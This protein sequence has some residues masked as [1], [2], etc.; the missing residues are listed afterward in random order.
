MASLKKALFKSTVPKAEYTEIKQVGGPVKLAS[1][2]LNCY[3]VICKIVR[4]PEL[5]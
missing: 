1:E 3:P 2:G 5:S 4:K